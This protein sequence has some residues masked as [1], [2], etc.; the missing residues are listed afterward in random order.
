[1][2]RDRRSGRVEACAA[3]SEAVLK[4]VPDITIQ[5]LRWSLAGRGH[6]FGFGTLQRFLARHRITRKKK[7]A[8]AAKQERPDVLKRREEWFEE[9][10]DPDPER[11]VFIDETWA[12]TN[13]ARRHGWAPRG[14]LLRVSVPHGHWKTTT[15]TAG[16]ALRGMIAPFVLDWPINR[17]AFESYVEQVLVPK[18]RQGDTVIMDD[19]SSHKG[20]GCAK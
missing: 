8:H 14:E 3:L 20:P 13:M 2:G 6:H 18:L 9:Q 1:M 10:L 4:E 11:L 5:E 17:S 12:S 19:L 15:F 7:T 16:L